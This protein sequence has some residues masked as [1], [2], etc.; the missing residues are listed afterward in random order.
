[1]S[2][3]LPE[4]EAAMTGLIRGIAP[5]QIGPRRAG[6]ENPRHRV[7]H[8]AR[9][10]P[11]PAAPIRPAGWTKHRLEHGPLLVGEVHAVG[12]D[13]DRIVVSLPARS[14]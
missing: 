6:A 10:R 4:L 8:A 14:L 2:R 3:P 1:M 7:Q 5:Q 12:Y 11:W 9:I 13:G